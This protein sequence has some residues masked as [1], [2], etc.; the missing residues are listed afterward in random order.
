MSK[1]FDLRYQLPSQNYMYFS[2]T[3]IPAL[4]AEAHKN[5]IEDL[6]EA[7]FYSATTDLWSS[8][9]VEPY[10]SLTVHYVDGR[11]KLQSK[12]LQ[13]HMFMPA[14]PHRNQDSQCFTRNSGVMETVHVHVSVEQLVCMTSGYNVIK[15]A[16]E[17]G[18]VRLSCFGHNL[19]NAVNNPIKDDVRMSCATVYAIR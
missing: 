7:H 10:I 15:A 12:C 16:V 1:V 17:L 9:G 4:Y 19:H 2:R 18:W 3:T 6:Y 8:V 11:W 14:G 13:T 5:M